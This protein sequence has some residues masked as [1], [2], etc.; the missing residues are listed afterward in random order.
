MEEEKEEKGENT[1]GT[2]ADDNIVASKEIQAQPLAHKSTGSLFYT[3]GQTSIECVDHGTEELLKQSHLSHGGVQTSSELHNDDVALSHGGTQTSLHVETGRIPELYN[4]DVALSNGRTQT[5]LH[6]LHDDDVALSHGG[7]QTSLHVGTGKIP[8]LHDDDVALSHGGTQTSLH[9]ETGRIPELYDDDMALSHGRTQ[10]SLHGLHD[11]DVALSHGG[12]Q[13]SLHVGTGKIPELHDDDV[14]LSHGG[15]QTSLHVETGR[16]PELYDDDVALSHRRTQTSL[17]GLHDDDVALSHGGTQTSLH[18]G[19][20]K[21]PELH[22]DDVALS[23]G[24]TQTSLHVE[25]G[26]IPELYNDDV[27][28]SHRRTQT[29]LHGL[30]DDDVALSHGE[31]QTSLDHDGTQTSLD[32]DGTQTSLDHDGT[33][34]SLDHDGTQT[35]L[36]HDGTQTSLHGEI[37]ELHDVH[38]T[39]PL[40]QK[41]KVDEQKNRVSFYLPPDIKAALERFLSSHPHDEEISLPGL[42]RM[43]LSINNEQ[44]LPQI[45]LNDELYNFLGLYDESIPHKNMLSD[46]NIEHVPRKSAQ[47]LSRRDLTS[48]TYVRSS[49]TEL[50][51]GRKKSEENMNAP[52]FGESWLKRSLLSDEAP[53]LQK[54]ADNKNWKGAN[55]DTNEY[56]T[57]SPNK[58][59]KSMKRNRQSLDVINMERTEEPEIVHS[60]AGQEQSFDRRLSML[61][62]LF[63]SDKS[64]PEASIDE[65]FPQLMADLSLQSLEDVK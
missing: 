32:H 63:F 36:D 25:T 47:I 15:T 65:G 42:G 45:D 10:T 5:S 19:T 13:T 35:S 38:D 18:V 6:G 27:A 51:M 34:T 46:K 2:Q 55:L 30:H 20:G 14:A 43:Q 8:E 44:W 54:G 11:D 50:A 59:K 49:D 9:V 48:P 26:R 24:G 3:D 1:E 56:D 17:H 53:I 37:S 31:A 40:F 23:H 16:I 28:L 57:A 12:T 7:T 33:Q 61:S 22:D 60:N 4:D 52:M 39:L 21:I 29:S 64:L 58:S 62:D 41:R